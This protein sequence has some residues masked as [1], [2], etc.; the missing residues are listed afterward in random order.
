VDKGAGVTELFLVRKNNCADAL[1]VSSV[2]ASRGIP[3]LLTDE[4][5]ATQLNA[6]AAAFIGAHHPFRVYVLG[7]AVASISI[8]V[9]AEFVALGVSDVVRLAGPDRIATAKAVVDA[10]LDHFQRAPVLFGVATG[11][12]YP[13]ALAG[14]AAFGNRGGVLLLADPKALSASTKDPLTRFA[15]NGSSVEI[16]GQD[17]AV[18]SSAEQQIVGM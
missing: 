1:A 8:E 3:V 13:D 2:A 18:S 6:E 7:D 4:V 12:N 10:L 15:A 5:P 14:G 11:Y 17:S 16:F 9:E